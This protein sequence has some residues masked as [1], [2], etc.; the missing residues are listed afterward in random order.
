LLSAL[1]E[2]ASAMDA[3]S[4]QLEIHKHELMEFIRSLHRGPAATV[5]LVWDML[6]EKDSLSRQS[7][8]REGIAQAITELDRNHRLMSTAIRDFRE[9]LAK[10]FPFKEGF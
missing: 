6:Y 8:I 7:E 4:P 1:E 3:V 9:F 2:L 10:E 5:G